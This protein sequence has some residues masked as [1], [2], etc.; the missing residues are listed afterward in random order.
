MAVNQTRNKEPAVSIVNRSIEGVGVAESTVDE[1]NCGLGAEFGAIL[2]MDA[3]D[4]SL[5]LIFSNEVRRDP[6]GSCHGSYG[7]GVEKMAGH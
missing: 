2:D 4:S 3:R 5:D 1:D 7:Q 6:A